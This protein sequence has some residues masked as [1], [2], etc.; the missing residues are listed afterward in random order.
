M[1]FSAAGGKIVGFFFGGEGKNICHKKV[2][3]LF[4]KNFTCPPSENPPTVLAP[5][6]PSLRA[7]FFQGVEGIGG[8]PHPNDLS[9]PQAEKIGEFLGVEVEESR[10]KLSSKSD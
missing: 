7:F 8:L 3:K 10:K 1:I 2:T 5:P 9:P 6:P 4:T